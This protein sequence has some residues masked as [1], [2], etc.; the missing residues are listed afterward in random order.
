MRVHGTA[1]KEIVLIQFEYVTWNDVQFL[2]ENSTINKIPFYYSVVFIF[3]KETDLENERNKLQQQ[4]SS[5]K[6]QYEQKVTGLESQIAALQT[7]WEFDKTSTQHKIVSTGGTCSG[8]TW[9][10]TIILTKLVDTLSECAYSELL[11]TPID[12]L[13]LWD[14][15]YEQR[16]HWICLNKAL[17]YLRLVLK[18][19]LFY[20]A[21]W[22]RKMN[23]LMKAEKSMRVH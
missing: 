5:E 15:K 18:Q 17:E 20:R 4:L 12:V 19:S 7:A 10:F 8:G 13:I 1:A 23:I 22:R 11:S 3:L 6:H 2:S 16:T 21:S 9:V 14:I